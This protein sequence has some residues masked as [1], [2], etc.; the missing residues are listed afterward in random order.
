MGTKYKNYYDRSQS[1]KSP[2]RSIADQKYRDLITGKRTPNGYYKP[3]KK[4]SSR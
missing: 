3:G 2:Q 4:N 1:P